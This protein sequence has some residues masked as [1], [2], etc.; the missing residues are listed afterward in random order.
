[1]MC[2]K[3]AVCADG[4]SLACPSMLGLPDERLEAQGWMV[5]FSDGES[6][7]AFLR[8]DEDVGEAWVFSSDDVEP[9]NVAAAVK[10][11]RPNLPVYLVSFEESGSLRS[12][13]QA[14]NL[15]GV[16]DRA[17]FLARYSFRKCSATRSTFPPKRPSVRSSGPDA[18][19]TT[20]ADARSAGFATTGACAPQSAPSGNSAGLAIALESEF[21]KGMDLGMLSKGSPSSAFASDT[22]VSSPCLPSTAAVGPS[23]AVSG[24]K[25]CVIVVASAS[26]GSGKSTVST[27]VASFASGMGFK[28]AVVDGDLQF[29]DVHLMLGVSEPCRMDEIASGARAMPASC[30]EGRPALLA[31]PSKVEDSELLASSFPGILDAAIAAFDVVVVNTGSLWTEQHAMLLERASTVLMVVGQGASSLR[32]TKRAV[33]MLGRCGLPLAPVRYVLNGCKRGA[34]LSSIDVSCALQGAPVFELRDGGRDVDE[35][36]A[37]GLVSELI[38]DENPLCVS[39]EALLDEILPERSTPLADSRRQDVRSRGARGRLSR[40]KRRVSCLC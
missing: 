10:K 18:P 24:K 30:D 38:D 15:D 21:L 25:A 34:P 17:Q 6:M 20:V 2:G 23:P 3:I 26:G 40:L 16:L 36:L 1:M 37:A 4:E 29:G 31:A 19:C 28:T 5:P 9:I 35:L 39:I 13:A 14:A 22:P 12:R 8:S 27:L 7:R 32:A 11:D 33:E